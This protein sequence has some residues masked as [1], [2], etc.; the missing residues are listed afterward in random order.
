MDKTEQERLL[1]EIFKQKKQIDTLQEKLQFM[2]ILVDSLTRELE[3]V[4]RDGRI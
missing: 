2:Y 4:R 3:N 1:A